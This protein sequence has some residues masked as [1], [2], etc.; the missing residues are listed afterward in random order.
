MHIIEC[1]VRSNPFLVYYDHFP[2]YLAAAGV[3]IWGKYYL[4]SNF[5]KGEAYPDSTLA[6]IKIK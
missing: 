3:G 1:A 2:Q 4:T 6:G 5:D